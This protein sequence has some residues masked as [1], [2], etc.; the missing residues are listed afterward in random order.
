METKKLMTEAGALRKEYRELPGLGFGTLVMIMGVLTG[1]ITWIYYS[2]FGEFNFVIGTVDVMIVGYLAWKTIYQTKTT[3][4]SIITILWG[5]VDQS[6]LQQGLYVVFDFLGLK[7]HVFRYPIQA[8]QHQLPGEDGNIWE[9]KKTVDGEEIYEPLPRDEKG[10]I[11]KAPNGMPW[12]EPW[13]VNFNDCDPSSDKEIAFYELFG[14]HLSKAHSQNDARRKAIKGT[15][16]VMVTIRILDALA[17][18]FNFGGEDEANKQID[19]KAH[20]ISGAEI[21]RLTLRTVQT[22]LTGLSRLCTY[23]LMRNLAE[24]STAVQPLPTTTEELAASETELRRILK[25]LGYS[26]KLEVLEPGT[27]HSLGIALQ[28]VAI[29]AAKADAKVEEARGTV[30]QADATAY[31]TLTEGEATAEAAAYLVEKSLKAQ[32]T[33]RAAAIAAMKKEGVSP[34]P[35]RMYELDA[36]R[37]AA[38]ASKPINVNLAGT[39]DLLAQADALLGL[40]TGKRRERRT[41]PAPKAAPTGTPPSAKK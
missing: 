8:K 27:S 40:G 21:C 4:E 23:Q 32:G 35:E 16:S 24:V 30:T 10:N 12:V 7:T 15:Y 36:A 1:I 26:I 11:L 31:K 25:E 17:Y 2:I 5:Y 28:G 14:I 39:V 19:D 3:T 20:L 9:Q 18:H 34:T 41:P 33:G 6:D 22:N 38:T 13:R 29:E 37:D